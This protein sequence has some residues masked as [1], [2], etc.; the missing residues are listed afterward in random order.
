MHDNSTL[1]DPHECAPSHRRGAQ[2]SRV[3]AVERRRRRT[4]SRARARSGRG[5]G[6]LKSAVIRPNP[7]TAAAPLLLG[8]FVKVPPTLPPA[9]FGRGHT[10]IADALPHRYGRCDLAPLP[11]ASATGAD[12]IQTIPRRPLGPA[13]TQP[14][15]PGAV[16]SLVKVRYA[17]DDENPR[18]RSHRR[19]GPAR[20]RRCDAPRMDS[21]RHFSIARGSRN[22]TVGEGAG[23]SGTVGSLLSVIVAGQFRHARPVALHSDPGRCSGG[24]V[25]DGQGV[26]LDRSEGGE[27]FQKRPGVAVRR[28][29]GGGGQLVEPALLVDYHCAAPRRCPPRVLWGRRSPRSVSSSR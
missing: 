12:R 13:A 3:V 6:S 28:G 16:A 7:R 22:M 20:P 29:G 1:S 8:V 27:V 23:A 18:Y 5:I 21:S 24:R 11:V 26:F 2:G 25:D 19:Y 17:P 4:P 15:R 10:P 14:C 9:G